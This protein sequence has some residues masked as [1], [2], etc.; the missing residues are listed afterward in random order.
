MGQVHKPKKIEEMTQEELE[1]LMSATDATL[2]ILSKHIEQ[3]FDRLQ[4]FIDC[5]RDIQAKQ[6]QIKARRMR[7][8]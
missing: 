7:K 1:V 4:P 8:L 2:S 3:L 6:E 5:I